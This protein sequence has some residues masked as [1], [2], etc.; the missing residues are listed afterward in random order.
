MR[1][2]IETFC[3]CDNDVDVE[4]QLCV[5]NGREFFHLINATRSCELRKVTEVGFMD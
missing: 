2:L 3:A 1:Y 4:E 5:T